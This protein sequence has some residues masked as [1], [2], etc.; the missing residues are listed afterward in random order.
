MTKPNLEERITALEK[1]VAEL[2]EA[3]ANG[4]RPKDWRRTIGVFSGAEMMPQ[5]FDE[6]LKY[7]ENDRER[8]RRRY[9]K[10]R[11]SKP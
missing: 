9:D 4:V 5:V 3:L 2:K 8:A 10:S 6:A 1:Q 7:R 11:R